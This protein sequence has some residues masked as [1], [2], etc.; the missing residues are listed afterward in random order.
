MH[1]IFLFMIPT[2]PGGS[3]MHGGKPVSLDEFNRNPPGWVD[4]VFSATSAQQTV[5][6]AADRLF[7]TRSGELCLHTVQLGDHPAGASLLRELAARLCKA[8]SVAWYEDLGIQ[9]NR[10]STL[11]SYLEEILTSLRPKLKRSSVE[12]QIDAQ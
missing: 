12:I 3:I 9:M 2:F 6:D 11:V 4:L 8:E 7:A 5:I 1:Y 10:H